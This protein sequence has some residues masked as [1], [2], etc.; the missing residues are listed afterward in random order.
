M[1]KTYQ[2]N[3]SEE[4]VELIAHKQV[5]LGRFIPDIFMSHRRFHIVQPRQDKLLLHFT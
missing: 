1:D 3:D 4:I 2:P 5:G